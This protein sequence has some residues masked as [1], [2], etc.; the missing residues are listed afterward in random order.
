MK[1]SGFKNAVQPSFLDMINFVNM[2]SKIF[3]FALT[4][5][6]SNAG[7]GSS[8]DPGKVLLRDVQVLTLK[9]GQMTT[10]MY[11]LSSIYWKRCLSH[12]CNHLR[13]LENLKA[14]AMKKNKDDSRYWRSTPHTDFSKSYTI[15]VIIIKIHISISK[16]KR[17]M[18]FHQIWRVC[19]K[20]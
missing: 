11:L 5:S 17:E 18:N 9:S 20:K 15:W 2:I 6:L 19:L 13:F 1:K 14:L 10:G 7:W 16:T 12:K 4:L 3:I 8:N